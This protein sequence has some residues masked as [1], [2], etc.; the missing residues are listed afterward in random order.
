M[1]TRV[2]KQAGQWAHLRTQAQGH[3]H[4][5]CR[6]L[7]FCQQGHRSTHSYRNTHNCRQSAG[8]PPRPS[9]CQFLTA[10]SWPPSSQGNLA[11][12]QFC[13]WLSASSLLDQE[14]ESIF[15]CSPWTAPPPQERRAYRGVSEA[16]GPEKNK[17]KNLSH[18]K[19]SHDRIVITVPPKLC[20]HYIRKR[21]RLAEVKGQVFKFP[22]YCSLSR[23]QLPRLFN[24]ELIMM[25]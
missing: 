13:R 6:A 1:H 17:T 3:L 18:P 4:T 21:S 7:R 9:H 15:R 25:M 14:T 20:R 19:K 16:G 12:L 23:P 2:C 24:E 10:P 8:E 11:L 5:A 22:P